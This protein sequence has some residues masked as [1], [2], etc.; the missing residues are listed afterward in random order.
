MG[1]LIVLKLGAL[2]SSLA[3]GGLVLLLAGGVCYTLGTIFYMLKKI[4]YMHAVWHL[5][6]LAGSVCHI[7]SVQ[8]YVI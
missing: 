2:L 8:L 5:W 6:V 1:W 4:P 3:T 7:L